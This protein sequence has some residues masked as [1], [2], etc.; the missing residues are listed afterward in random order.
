MSTTL[1]EEVRKKSGKD[2]HKTIALGSTRV[3]VRD[4]HSF[5]NISKLLKVTSHGVALRLPSQSPHEHFSVSGVPKLV[6]L[7][8]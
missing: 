3:L 7:R 5:Q 8:P 4:D 1:E 6:A 2:A